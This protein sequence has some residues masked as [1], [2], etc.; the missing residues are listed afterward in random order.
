M[1]RAAV[2]RFDAPF[3]A[4]MLFGIVSVASIA[5]FA[6]AAATQEVAALDAAG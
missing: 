3:W 6:F 2:S 5:C 1:P 4:L